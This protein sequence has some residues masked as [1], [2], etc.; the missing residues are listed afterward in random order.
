MI[1]DIVEIF[2]DLAKQHKLIRSFKYE[3]LS[4]AMGTGED[5]YPMFFLEDPVYIDDGTTNGGTNHATINFDIIMTPQAFQNYNMKQLSELDCQNTAQSIALNIIAKL[6]NEIK[7]EKISS[8]ID[9]KSWS[10][11]T[12]RRY[13]DDSTS[14][15]RCTLRVSVP[16]DIYYCDLDEH[17]NKDKNFSTEKLLSDIPTDNAEGCITFDYKLPNINLE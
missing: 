3:Q 4:K 6:R 2:Y 11:L 14:G 8:I 1:K 10:F 9:V 7:E 13:Y 5:N 12:L 15:I 16:N 17:F